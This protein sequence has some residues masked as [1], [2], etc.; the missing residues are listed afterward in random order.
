MPSS[1]DSIGSPPILLVEDDPDLQEFGRAVIQSQGYTVDIAGDGVQAVRMVMARTYALVF[2][3]IDMPV[4]DGFEAARKIR[5]H[6]AGRRHV[7]I[8]AVTGHGGDDLRVQ[9]LATGMN[10]CVTKPVSVATIE[11]LLH[12][13]AQ[14]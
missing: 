4:M 1:T 7:P 11:R 10:D 9:C 14:K 6:E 2:M 13:W 8:I 12:L 3:D 5:A